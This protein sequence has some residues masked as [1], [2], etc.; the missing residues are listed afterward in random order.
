[1]K[2][3]LLTSVVM[4]MA[5]GL[6]AQTSLTHGKNALLAGDLNTYR[7]I[8]FYDPGNSGSNQIWDFSLIQ[9]T[10]KSPVST[11]IAASIPKMGG[12][13]DY[14][15]S[16]SDSGND[17]FMNSSEERLEE[18]GYDNKE[19]KLTLKYSDPVVKMK[20]PFSYKDQFADHFIGIALY[21]ET[22]TIDFFGDCTVEADAYGTLILPDQV[23]DNVLRVKSVKKGWQINMC[24]TTKVNIVKYMW[25]A[26]GYRYPLLSISTVENVRDTG[27]PEIIKSA[28]TNTTQLNERGAVIIPKDPAKQVEKPGVSVNIAPNPFSTTL[29]F[30]YV[31]TA[32]I[33]VSIEL[34]D[35]S[36]KHIGWLVDNQ[37]QS[38]GY[39]TGELNAS[40]YSLMPGT[41]FIR[42]TFNNQVVNHKIVKI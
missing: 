22:N 14:N 39:H 30:N 9:Y 10:G 35:M 11:I 3:I 38:V 42:F 21:N 12:V 17:Y 15:L 26:S 5:I 6:F 8:Q 20:Y 29:T 27:A 24:G 33:P 16:L 28:F 34:Y 13:G 36:G 37:K 32:Q 4:L 41:Y 7:E 25:Y 31:L 1:M 18:W 40:T 19:L 2:T 23:I